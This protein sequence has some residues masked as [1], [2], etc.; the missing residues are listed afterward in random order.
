M[1]T[2]EEVV[3]LV[4]ARHGTSLRLEGRC[5]GGEVGAFYALL[6]D[7]EAIVFKWSENPE[8]ERRIRAVVDALNQAREVGYPVPRYGPVLPFDGGVLIGQ[9]RVSGA[10]VDDVSDALGARLLECRTA[11]VGRGAAIDDGPWGEFVLRTLREGADGWALHE[12][13]RAHSTATRQVLEWIEDVGAT[14]PPSAFHDRDL[15][16]LDFHHRNALQAGDGELV[17]IVD[18]EGARQGDAT[19]DLVT[20]AF[21]L[22]VASCS[23]GLV[24]AV[25]A[26]AAGATNGDAL[27]AYVAHMALRRLDW[28]IR[29]H[30]DEVAFWLGVCH[31]AR[32]RIA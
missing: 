9:Q 8:R 20:L 32:R 6:P 4:E 24:A 31:D 7:G 15:V 18:A 3:A 28:T 30:P 19:F 5:P 10:W 23:A 2:A 11:T 1:L 13:L 26:E 17:A 12:P 25:W 21:G 22:S 29:F 14:T 27:Q 16:H